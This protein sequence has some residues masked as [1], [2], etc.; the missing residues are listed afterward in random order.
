MKRFLS[1]LIAMVMVLS[2]IPA[3]SLAAEGERTVYVDAK[4]GNNNNDGLS[5]TAP[6][7]TLATAYSKLSGA[8]AG[9]IAGRS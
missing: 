9:R 5:E 8:S 2:L 1:L 7:K 4:N 6:V 3:V